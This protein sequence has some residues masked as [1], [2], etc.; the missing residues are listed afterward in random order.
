MNYHSLDHG[1]LY[2]LESDPLELNNLLEEPAV[3]PLCAER[4]QK[5][6]DAS[7]AACDPGPDQ[8]GRF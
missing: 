6:F 3:A 4:T 8:I 7:V 1:E 5:S 2:D